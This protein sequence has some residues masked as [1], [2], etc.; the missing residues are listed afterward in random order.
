[1]RSKAYAKVVEPVRPM[2]GNRVS[3]R[4]PQR[5]T[6]AKMP[7]IAR[8]CTALCSTVRARL[9]LRLCVCMYVYVRVY[10]CGYFYLCVRT[11]GRKSVARFF[12]P[13]QSTLRPLSLSF[14]VS[15]LRPAHL[16]QFFQS[17]IPVSCTH[18]MLHI[19]PAAPSEDDTSSEEAAAAAAADP[20]R[21]GNYNKQA[22]FEKRNPCICNLGVLTLKL[23]I[24]EFL[25]HC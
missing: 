19:W 25:Q 12:F 10:V 15:T 17:W 3:F 1:M 2:H 22:T 4:F 11:F 14:R 7:S 6:V 16:A 9:R 20:M 13:P 21:R 5:S 18:W 23:A 8:Y 24:W